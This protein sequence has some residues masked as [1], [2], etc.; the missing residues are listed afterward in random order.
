MRNGVAGGFP[1]QG[2]LRMG[3]KVMTMLGPCREASGFSTWLLLSNRVAPG[4]D[5]RGRRDAKESSEKLCAQ[6]LLVC[7][8]DGRRKKLPRESVDRKSPK[9]QNLRKKIHD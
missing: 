3:L 5:A 4:I 1:A 6:Q 8:Q 9:N 7:K 2:T